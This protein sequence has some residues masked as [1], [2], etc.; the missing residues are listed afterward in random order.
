M[1]GYHLII[2]AQKIV[3]PIKLIL[4]EELNVSDTSQRHRFKLK[5]VSILSWQLLCNNNQFTHSLIELHSEMWSGLHK[6]YNALMAMFSIN[7]ICLRCQACQ[8]CG[9][10]MCVANNRVLPEKSE[11]SSS[12]ELKQKPLTAF[13]PQL[14]WWITHDDNNLAAAEC[15][16]WWYFYWCKA[17]RSLYPSFEPPATLLLHEPRFVP[18]AL[19]PPR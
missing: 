6:T 15:F 17:G 18:N 12:H 14:D 8:A 11:T 1:T 3:K 2:S 13:K 19:A 4:R 5:I 7:A 9:A 16:G 10:C